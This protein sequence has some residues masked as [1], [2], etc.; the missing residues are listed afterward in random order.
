MSAAIEIKLPRVKLRQLAIGSEK[1][2]GRNDP[3]IGLWLSRE[4]IPA[5]LALA[6]IADPMIGVAQMW[7]CLDRSH[8]VYGCEMKS[9]GMVFAR[10]NGAH[11]V[12]DFAER[13]RPPVRPDLVAFS[14]AYPKNDH[15]SGKTQK[16]IDLVKKKGLHAS[17]KIEGTRNLLPVFLNIQ[18]YRE[19]A[20]VAVIIRNGIE[21]QVE[22]DVASEV[23]ASMNFAGLG[24]VTRYWYRCKPGF[25]DNIKRSVNP[26]FRIIE[27]EYIL[28]GG[29]K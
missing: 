10:A 26:R 16:Q 5:D 28:I 3:R 18:S 13:W 17:Q 21:D 2:P 8:E 12:C 7:S 29:L 22:V 14:H 9:S 23:E 27:K 19:G 11:A 1:W 24:P 20:P 15:D 4:F 25:F 6:V